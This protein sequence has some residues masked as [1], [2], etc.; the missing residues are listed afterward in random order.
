MADIDWKNLGFKYMDTNCHIEYVWRDGKWSAGE[1]VKEPFLKMHIAATCLH[2]GQEAF[3]GMKAFRCKDGV[4]RIFRPHENAG[5]MHRTALRTCM[6]PVPEDMFVDAVKRVVKANEE[7]VPP[8]GTG[9][10]LYVRPLLIG[11]GPQRIH[12]SGARDACG[13]VL[14]GWA[15][16]RSLDYYR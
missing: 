6:A 16:A 13:R 10:S 14:Q 4:I 7:F 9:G 3:E 1:L 2:Y 8:Y 11:T 5:R 15:E 12:V